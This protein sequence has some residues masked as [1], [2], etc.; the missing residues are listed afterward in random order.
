MRAPRP[1]LRSHECSFPDIA[2][3]RSDSESGSDS[4]FR[5]IEDRRDIAIAIAIA[6]VVAIT[7]AI[8]ITPHLFPPRDRRK[9]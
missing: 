8:A 7:I 9:P 6:I 5:E 1:N 2:L 4:A 3:Q